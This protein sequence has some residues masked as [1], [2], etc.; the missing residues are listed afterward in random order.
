[1][2]WTHP[3]E[4]TY[5]NHL[6]NRTLATKIFVDMLNNVLQYNLMCFFS[7]ITCRIPCL[8]CSLNPE[9]LESYS[10]VDILISKKPKHLGTDF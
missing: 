8:T 3:L 4:I 10:P 6:Q 2:D 9:L 1:M 5:Q 7:E